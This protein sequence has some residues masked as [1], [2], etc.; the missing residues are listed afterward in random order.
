ML[1]F[2]S[3][4]LSVRDVACGAGRGGPAPE[5]AAARDEVAF[6]RRGVFVRHRGSARSVAEEGSVV[7]F[8]R[9]E[10]YR[11]SHPTCGGDACTVI[12]LAPGALGAR[13]LS[14][15]AVAAPA[16][17]RLAWQRL[18]R[19]LRGGPRGPAGPLAVEETAL[20]LA[21]GARERA[22]GRER[23]AGTAPGAA[24]RELVER[25]REAL[26]GTG[27]GRPGLARLARDVGCSPW[28]LSRAFRAETGATLAQHALRRRLALALERVLDGERDLTA[29]AL[30]L[31][32][33][34]HSHLTN[35]FRREYG[36][37]P[38]RLRP[39]RSGPR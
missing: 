27:G 4:L 18:L 7:L 21:L 5:E 14:L 10:P 15:R 24:R 26:A 3:D 39:R 2:A 37:P 33:A 16:A 1:L 38:S 17:A 22:E 29:L 20:E 13:P 6:V 8:G 31:G 36:V 11:V 9:D 32:F 23:E 25:A 12:E 30:E 35:A 34:H 28:H 19:A